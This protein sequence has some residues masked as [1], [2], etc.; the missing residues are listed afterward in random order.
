MHRSYRAIFL[1][2]KISEW[3]CSFCHA[4]VLRRDCKRSSHITNDGINTATHCRLLTGVAEPS[5]LVPAGSSTEP[6]LRPLS[7]TKCF[8]FVRSGSSLAR[9]ILLGNQ[10]IHRYQKTLSSTE[11]HQSSRETRLPPQDSRQPS[12]H[13]PQEQRQSRVSARRLPLHQTQK[14]LELVPSIFVIERHKMLQH[15]ERRTSLFLY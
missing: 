8:S 4:I 15:P 5:L 6:Q 12:S 14:S 11:A 3:R 7:L 9:T 10:V 2:K 1:F 13:P